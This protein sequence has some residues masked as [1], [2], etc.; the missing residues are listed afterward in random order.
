MRVGISLDSHLKLIPPEE[1]SR[2][3]CDS[4]QLSSHVSHLD[5]KVGDE[6]L[7]TAWVLY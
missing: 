3:S 2:D 7:N 1:V 4:S 5:S 6:V